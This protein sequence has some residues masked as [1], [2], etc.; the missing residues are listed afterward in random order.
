[1]PTAVVVVNELDRSADVPPG[2]K[3]VLLASWDHVLGLDVQRDARAGW[4]PTAE[5]RGLMAERDEART[6]KDYEESDRIRDLLTS[7][8]VEVM[9]TAEG[10][11][12]RPRSSPSSG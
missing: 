10:T 6:A 1:M 9:D 8:G 11:K 5:M 7:M 2:E 3:Y 4:E 12:V